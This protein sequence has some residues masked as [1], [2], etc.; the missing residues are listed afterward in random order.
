MHSTPPLTGRRQ[1]PAPLPVSQA[2]PL[3]LQ[4]SA[5]SVDLPSTSPT[6][7]SARPSRRPAV[8]V[9]LAIVGAESRPRPEG[10]A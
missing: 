7:T 1:R 9:H 3:G 10:A 5:I 8:P 6:V 2:H 4:L